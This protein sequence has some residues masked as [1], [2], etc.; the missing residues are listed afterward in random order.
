MESGARPGAGAAL[1]CV[2]GV[3]MLLL[4]G[5]KVHIEITFQLLFCRVGRIVNITNDDTVLEQSNAGTHIGSMVQVVFAPFKIH[6][7]KK[8]SVYGCVHPCL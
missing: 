8:R 3:A 7:S 6:T 5:G 1:S 4:L 2:D